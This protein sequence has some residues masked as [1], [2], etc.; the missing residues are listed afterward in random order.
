M[1][2]IASIPALEIDSASIYAIRHHHHHRFTCTPASDYITSQSENP[3]LYW[4]YAEVEPRCFSHASKPTL[5]SRCAS[6]IW[7]IKL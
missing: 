7:M 6:L 4:K 3:H 1:E 5:S 2:W